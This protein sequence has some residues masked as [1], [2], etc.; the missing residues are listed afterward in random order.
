[1]KTGRFFW[2]AFFV[3]I[4]LLFLLNNLEY[5]HVDWGYS[6]RL[7]PLIL[8]FWGL[9]KFTENRAFRA[10]LSIFN[11]I[12]FACMVFGFFSFQWINNSFDDTD[13][14]QYSQHFS[15]PYDSTI[16]KASFTFGG[17]AGRFV[18]EEPTRELVEAR[19]ES[20]FGQ[21]ELKTS[22]DDGMTNVSFRMRDRKSFHFFNRIKNRADIRLNDQPTWVMRFETGASRL[23]LDLRPYKAEKVTI[24]AG[25]CSIRV[26]LGDRLE[27]S[28]LRVKTGVSTVRIEIP[29]SSGCE[30]RDNS[31]VGSTDYVGF[32]KIENDTWQSDNFDNA[33]KKIY[34]DVDT[35]V[36]NVRVVRY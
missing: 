36:S 12:I 29:S 26:K 19:T 6:W 20:G 2:G 24:D 25:V 14:I 23:D 9:S 21:Y 33:T 10:G 32:S 16:D 15:E 31:H 4:G 22:D 27:E 28:N 7:W 8:I 5:I 3:V 13:P 17:G 34:I 18:M 30:I 35:G 11:G 1:M